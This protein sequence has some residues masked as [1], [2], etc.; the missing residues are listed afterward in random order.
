MTALEQETM[1]YG[2]WPSP[3]DAATAAAHDGSPEFVGVV[4]EEVWWTAPRP[5]EGGRR[6]LIRR[7]ADG[8]EECPL[9]APWNVRSRVIEYG[10]TPWAGAVADGSPVIVFVHFPDQRIY[11]FRPDEPGAG[12]RPLTPLSPVGGGLRWADLTLHPG[13]GE[14]WGVLEEFTGPGP[15][16]VRRVPVAVPLD[17]SAAEDRQAV[18]ELTAATHRFVT[19]PRLSPDGRRAAWIAWDHPRMPWDGT[20]LRV[21]DVTGDGLLT[22]ARTLMGG[23]E[24][25]VAQT[26]WAADGSLLA[27]TDRTGWWNVHRVDPDTGEAVN[28]C[29]RE[30]EFGGPMWKLGYRWFAPL[31]HGLIAVLHGVG[32]QRLGLLDPA[33][34]EVTAATGPWTEWSPSLAATGGR[35]VGIAAGAR[36]SHEIVELDTVTGRTRVIGGAHHDTVD[37]AYLPEAV[38][39]TFPGPDGREVHANVYPPRNPQATGDGPAPWA[40]WVH[41]GPTGRAGMVLDL[42][43]AYFT[44]RG[45]G[46]AEVNYGG[47]AGYGRAYRNRL[48]E[49]WGV[50]DVEDCAAVAA[51][52]VAEGAADPARLAIRGGSAGGWTS[53]AALTGTD[54]YACGTVLYP[55]LD[56]TAW[57]PEGG[58]THD[59]ESQYLES[60]IGPLA[61][62]PERYRDRSPVTR[63][64]GVSVPFLLLQGLDDVICPPV[65]CDRFL[66]ALAG[67]GIPHAYRAFEGEGHGFRRLDTL[68]TCLE[69]EL[70]L[71]AQVFGFTAAGVPELEL[72][73]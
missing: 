7:R 21:A 13:R 43:V 27:A 11:L 66:A 53:A 19:G 20:E 9:P 49:Q 44:S 36:T 4:G 51:G 29:P 42:E 17:G 40:V 64:D 31:Q 65:Q 28:L 6:A 58:E 57:S 32:G 54:T 3:I 39:R 67:R 24:E 68:V 63:A 12:P 71:Y 1:A 8:T 37:P 61:E 16:D 33:T 14:V 34:G 47:S 2:S 48:R 45:I 72:T 15:S 56:L 73:V 30:E 26:D 50:V 69:A 55:I 23:P 62:V 5:A 35:V 10:G 60:L 70:S 22:G 46:V 18:R 38:H 59:F 41:G 25:S 52:L